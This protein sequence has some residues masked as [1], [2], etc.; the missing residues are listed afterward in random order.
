MVED[1]EVV[2]YEDDDDDFEDARLVSLFLGQSEEEQAEEAVKKEA[3]DWIKSFFAGKKMY[4]GGSIPENILLSPAYVDMLIYYSGPEGLLEA[5]DRA[6]ELIE[7][8]GLPSAGTERRHKVPSDINLVV[9]FV[10]ECEDAG[11]PKYFAAGLMLM[12]LEL[13]YGLEE[14]PAGIAQ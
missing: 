11:V 14:L 6:Y 9:N 10:H 13:C 5:V 8:N 4:Y 1:C 7:M 3:R 12:T 2:G